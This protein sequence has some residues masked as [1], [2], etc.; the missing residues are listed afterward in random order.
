[1]V[2]LRRFGVLRTATVAA[3]L[4]AV[5][6]FVFFAILA[7]FVLVG[8]GSIPNLP[9][10]G[11]TAAMGGIG[12]LFVG[13]ILALI[14][15]VVGWVFTAIFCLIYNLA[16]RLT[17]GIEMELTTVAPPAP[18][19]QWAPAPPPSAPAPMVQQPAPQQPAPPPAATEPT[20]TPQATP[21]ATPPTSPDAP[22][23]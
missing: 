6:V 18:V 23:G 3:I 16:A 8:A 1:M 10:G 19:P 7:L 12:T 13:A 9:G 15:A 11:A 4:Y 14:Y 20:T 22:S 21:P 17:G 5:A 2:R